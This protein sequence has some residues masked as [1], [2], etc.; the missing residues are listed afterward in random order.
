VDLATGWKIDFIFRKSRAFS[1]MEF[2]RR[3]LVHL[4]GIDLFVASLEDVVVSKLEW[5][6]LAESARQ[7][8]D[9][10]GILRL[11]WNSLDRA[12]LEKWIHE[13]ALATE[14]NNVRQAAGVS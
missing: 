14:W 3:E 12:Y 13:L 10:A 2:S 9:V 1:E 5:A 11:R 6:K 4:Q 8:E 7:T